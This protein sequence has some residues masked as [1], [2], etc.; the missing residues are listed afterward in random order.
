MK[1]GELFDQCATEY[2]RDRQALV[3]CFDEFYG[4]VLRA[5]P[6]DNKGNIRVLELGAGTGL[7][8]AMVAKAFPAAHLHLTDISEAMLAQAKQRFAG[9]PFVTYALQE[10]T[11]LNATAEYD[12]VIS[13]LSIHHLE[14]SRTR[15]T[16][17]RDS[18][19]FMK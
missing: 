14:D 2:D 9:N 16:R 5:I 18:A 10:H 8:A 1:I 3:P 11:Q 19:R 13:A 12:L 17:T 7:L 15:D 4:T 6:F